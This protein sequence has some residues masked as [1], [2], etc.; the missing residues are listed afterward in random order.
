MKSIA[1]NTDY[2]ENQTLLQEVEEK[3]KIQIREDIKEFIKLNSGGYP[4]KDVIEAEGERHIGI[5]RS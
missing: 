1:Q 5:K 2:V 3:Y 4:L